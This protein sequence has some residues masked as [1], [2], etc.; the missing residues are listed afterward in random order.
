VIVGICCI[1]RAFRPVR[2]SQVISNEINR[3]GS[4]NVRVSDRP[5]PTSITITVAGQAHR[6]RHTQRTIAVHPQPHTQEELLPLESLSHRTGTSRVL[7]MYWTYEWSELEQGRV[8]AE[9][10]AYLIHISPYINPSGKH[11][12]TGRENRT[13]EGEK[14]SI[15]FF[16]TP[17]T[18]SR[19]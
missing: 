1:E 11:G 9:S 15:A 18:G 13:G 19:V 8:V 6:T 7:T 4:S 16:S 5:T 2:Y 14:T 12:E 3:Y 10:Y 17:R